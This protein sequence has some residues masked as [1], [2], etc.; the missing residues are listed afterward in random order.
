ML[1]RFKCHLKTE[2]L[3]AA[4]LVGGSFSTLTMAQTKW[5]L[6]TAYPATS[7][8]TENVQAFANDVEK[9]T[10]GKLKI[11][12]HANASLFKAPEIKRAVQGGQ[13]QIGEIIF[14]NFSNEHPLFELDSVPFLAP[15][16]EAAHKLHKASQKSLEALFAKQGMKL[17]YAVPWPPQ[18]IYVKKPIAS[19]ADLKGQKWRA[20]SPGTA[21]MGELMGAN[22]VTIQFAELSQA[23]ATGGVDSL[24]SSLATAYDTRIYE[25]ITHY[26]DVQ[27][28][29]PRNGVIVNQAAFDKLDKP[30]QEAVLKAAEAAET[31]GWKVSREKNSWYA[32]ELKKKGMT[33]HQPSA[34]LA[35]DMKKIGDTMLGD[36]LKKAGSE[37][38]AVVDAYRK[39]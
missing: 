39:M 6:P 22:P 13:A 31:R 26:Y 19:A 9:A 10:A 37:G 32:D 20:Y 27:A 12:L 35:T 15:S 24:I 34:Q 14:T 17:L 7:F 28:W 1:H 25:Q 8:Q 33:I 23:L 18:G 11:A 16:Y 21:K 5:D 3:A 4:L 30:T 36:W 2:L 38:Q 29:L